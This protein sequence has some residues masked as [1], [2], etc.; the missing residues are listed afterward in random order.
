ML[1]NKTV[2]FLLKNKYDNVDKA[3]LKENIHPR[4]IDDLLSSKE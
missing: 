2:S 4:I 3:E 1:M